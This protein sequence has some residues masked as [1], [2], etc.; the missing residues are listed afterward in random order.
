MDKILVAF[1]KFRNAAFFMLINKL[2]EDK[3]LFTYFYISNSPMQTTN[4]LIL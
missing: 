4:Q 3:R 2:Q 1:L